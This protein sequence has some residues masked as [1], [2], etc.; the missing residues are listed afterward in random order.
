MYVT[1]NNVFPDECC[2]R[3]LIFVFCC[4]S[5][6]QR[7]KVKSLNTSSCSIT[8][9]VL[10]PAPSRSNEY[11]KVP[12]GCSVGF[13][14]KEQFQVYC[15]NGNHLFKLGTLSIGVKDVQA[16]QRSKL[17]TLN[18]AE[19]SYFI[20]YIGNSHRETLLGPFLFLIKHYEKTQDPQH[21][22]IER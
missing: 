18:C 11:V 14:C 3:K 6:A 17:V 7:T 12:L 4:Y 22:F 5:Y 1:S 21:D 16:E 13:C 19:V 8:H 2:S 15:M 9:L 10:G 20:Y